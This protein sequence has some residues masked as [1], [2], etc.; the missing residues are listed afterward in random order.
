ML[1]LSFPQIGWTLTVVPSDS[2]IALTPIIL[3]AFT[4]SL[5]GF[6]NSDRPAK[7]LILES[8]VM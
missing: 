1:W 7:S 4:D 5:Y 2:D 3:G 8:L 6:W